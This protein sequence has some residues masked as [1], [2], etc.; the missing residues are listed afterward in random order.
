MYSSKCS[1][2]ACSWA[3]LSPSAAWAH[4]SQGALAAAAHQEVSCKR[5]SGYSRDESGT[6]RR[7]V[8]PFL[9]S[10]RQTGLWYSQKISCMLHPFHTSPWNLHHFKL[11]N[12][13]IICYP[14]SDQFKKLSLKRSWL[15]RDD[16][17]T[18]TGGCVCV[19]IWSS[20]VLSWLALVV[21][22]AVLVISWLALQ[23]KKSW[24]LLLVEERMS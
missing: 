16:W 17:W 22:T 4:A 1:S 2:T 10:N 7:N 5:A 21:K 24:S 20:F 15:I 3:F 23:G 8:T 12:S 6:F 18:W 13:K 14:F 9:L 11:Y 19:C